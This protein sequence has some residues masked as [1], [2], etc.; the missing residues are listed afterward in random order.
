MPV[1][2][3]IFCPLGQ[4]VGA[5]W[6][7][8]GHF[9]APHELKNRSIVLATSKNPR[10]RNYQATSH[11]CVES[12]ILPFGATRGGKMGHF[13]APHK[14]KNY[15]IVLGAQ[16][17]PRRRQFQGIRSTGIPKVDLENFHF[18]GVWSESGKNGHFLIPKKP[19]PQ[20]KVLRCTAK[21][22]RSS[23]GNCLRNPL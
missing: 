9:R 20:K 8:M 12:N 13:W 10:S 14:L 19:A 5:E 22:R 15:F 11:A 3:T 4:L 17:N 23:S 1:L 18:P 21:A 16:N 7:K 2:K 6:G